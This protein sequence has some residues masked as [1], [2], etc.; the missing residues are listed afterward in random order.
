MKLFR[1]WE[2]DALSAPSLSCLRDGVNEKLRQGWKLV[3]GVSAT[4]WYYNTYPAG[5]RS[6]YVQAIKRRQR[7]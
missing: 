7:R 1:E 4:C 3:G 6:E 5:D 2:Y